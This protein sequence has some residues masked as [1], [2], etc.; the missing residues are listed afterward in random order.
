MLIMSKGTS[1]KGMEIDNK[2]EYQSLLSRRDEIMKEEG[3]KINPRIA[4]RKADY[5]DI[6]NV[7][8]NEVPSGCIG[9][10]NFA[11]NPGGPWVSEYDIPKE[12]KDQLMQ[13]DHICINDFMES[14]RDLL[15]K[16]LYISE[17]QDELEKI[18]NRLKIIELGHEKVNVPL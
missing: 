10:V 1:N 2:A 5:V 14:M 3:K 18:N 8:G 11:R 9:R 13:S 17:N 12:I 15:N 4:E 7:Y 16:L 6:M